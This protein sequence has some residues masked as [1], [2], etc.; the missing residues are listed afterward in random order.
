LHY[1]LHKT[2]HSLLDSSSIFSLHI[3]QKPIR[4]VALHICDGPVL[5]SRTCECIANACISQEECYQTHFVRRVPEKIESM[6][7]M[8]D[9]VLITKNSLNIHHIPTRESHGFNV[10]KHILPETPITT[11]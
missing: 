10:S 2:E 5:K 6:T 3:R 7:E 4:D 1:H 9:R 11:K 8:N